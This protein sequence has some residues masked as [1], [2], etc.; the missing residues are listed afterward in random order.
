MK[1][2]FKK[3]SIMFVMLLAVIGVGVI[4]NGTVANAAID[5]PFEVGSSNLNNTP[6]NSAINKVSKL[7]HPEIGWNRYDDTDA[8][9]SYPEEKWTKYKGTSNI[10]VNSTA[11]YSDS[12]NSICKFN[13]TGNK[14]RIIS[15]LDSNHTYEVNVKID[16]KSAG[17]FSERSATQ[18]G[19]ILVY[20]NVNLSGGEHYIELT[21]L[22]NYQF[23]FD[24]VDVSG[25]LLAYNENAKNKS[26]DVDK[27]SIDLLEGKSEKLTATTTPAGLEVVWSSSDESVATV[28]KYGNVTAVGV[29][30]CTIKATINDGSNLSDSCIVNVTKK[31]ITE[32]TTPI[33]PDN[34]KALLIINL[35]DG[36]TKIFDVTNSEVSKFKQWYNTKTEYE[37]K[38]TYEFNKTVNSNISVEEDVVHNQITSYEIRKY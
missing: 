31:D 5:K 9:I 35:T 23:V 37:N 38:L 28:D 3:F 2:Y 25:N 36:E 34:T 26:I 29:G 19:Q 21:N 12:I 7:E 30:T 20:E 4:Q 17:S 22:V 32:P 1:N 18:K 27:S 14:I 33:V 8:N 6:E 15:E 11:T 13:F 10:W 24:A 16:G